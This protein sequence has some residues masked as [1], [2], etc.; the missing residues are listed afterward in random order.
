MGIREA[1]NLMGEMLWSALKG[2]VLLIRA[3]WR[4]RKDEQR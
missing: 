1:L 3:C 2:M 4:E